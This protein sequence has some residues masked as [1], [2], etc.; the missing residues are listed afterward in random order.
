MLNLTTGIQEK[1]RKR[2]VESASLA[3]VVLIIIWWKKKGN[4]INPITYTKWRIRNNR[5]SRSNST[6]LILQIWFSYIESTYICK[7][8]KTAFIIDH[9]QLSTCRVYTQILSIYFNIFFSSTVGW[10]YWNSFS[11]TQRR[12]VLILIF[13]LNTI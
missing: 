8:I 4:E 3:I 13:T 5:V 1:R 12:A 7:L 11:L 2:T 10:S 6:Y 9:Y